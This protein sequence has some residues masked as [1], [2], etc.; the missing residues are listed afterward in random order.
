[1]R[2]E[3]YAKIMLCFERF[4]AEIQNIKKSLM[5]PTNTE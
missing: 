1:M 4:P 5:K 2:F 3:P